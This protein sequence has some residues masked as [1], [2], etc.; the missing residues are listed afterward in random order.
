MRRPMRFATVL[1]V[2]AAL[3]AATACSSTPPAAENKT[4]K[5]VYQKSDSFTA[6][7]TVMQDAKKEFEAANSS[8]TVNLEPIQANDD[9]Y[10][11]KLALAQRSPD[12][13]PDVF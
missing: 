5:I 10:G 7:D 11:T 6:L 13:A 12:T 4:L 1:P 2:V 3:L 8:V 9:D